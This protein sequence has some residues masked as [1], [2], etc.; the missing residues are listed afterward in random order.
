MKIQWE[1]NLI[2]RLFCEQPKVM[3]CQQLEGAGNVPKL[4]AVFIGCGCVSVSE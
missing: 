2:E 3:G 1:Y 4:T